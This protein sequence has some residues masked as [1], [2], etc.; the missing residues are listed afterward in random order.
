M[1]F[2]ALVA[3]LTFVLAILGT[4]AAYMAWRNPNPLQST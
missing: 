1:I 3:F 2:K 4:I